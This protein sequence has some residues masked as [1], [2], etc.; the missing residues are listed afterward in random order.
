MLLD[1]VAP[2]AARADGVAGGP[3][4]VAAMDDVIDPVRGEAV[5]YASRRASVRPNAGAVA[6]DDAAKLALVVPQ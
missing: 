6:V 4:G 2:E 5:E 1:D 3:D